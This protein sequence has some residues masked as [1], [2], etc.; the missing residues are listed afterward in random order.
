MQRFLRQEISV[1]LINQKKPDP[2]RTQVITKRK[3]LAM[4]GELQID[5]VKDFCP[6]LN[7]NE[8]ILKNCNC[9][10]IRK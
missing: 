7:R 4:T 3:G 8:N 9:P 6:Y 5:F 10:N 1:Q 2:P